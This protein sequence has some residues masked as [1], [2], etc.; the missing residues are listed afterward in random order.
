MLENTLMSLNHTISPPRK[1]KRSLEAD[2]LTDR[3]LSKRKTAETV[4]L[5]SSPIQLT[6]IRDLPASCNLDT[7]NLKDILGDPLI[8]ECWQF[9]FLFD[10]DFLMKHFDEDTRDLVQVRIV[11]GSWKR[12]DGNKI[13][14]DEA[15]TRYKNIQAI[16]AYMP[17]PFGTHHSKMM[18]LLRHDDCA[19]VVIHTANMISQD[20]TNMTQAV[21]RSP[22]LPLSSI[23][24]PEPSSLIGSGARFKRDLLAYLRV[25][26][27]KRTGPL[28]NQLRKFD[29]S[30]V[31]A[32]LV[33]STPSRQNLQSIDPT[34]ETLWGWPGLQ[35]ILKHVPAKGK[36]E[37]NPQIVA[38]ISSIA[39]LGQ[40]NKWLK[41]TFLSTLS[42]TEGITDGAKPEL[43]IIFPTA[44]EIRR[45]LD[46]YISGGSIH[47][48]IQSP[49]Q[50][51]Q[52]DYLRPMMCHWAGD[53]EGREVEKGTVRE[54]GRRRAAPHIKTYIRFTDHSMSEIDWAMVTSANLSTQAWGAAVN[55][56]RE[57]RICSWEIGV[58]VWPDLL[59]ESQSNA[60]EM[61]PVFKTDMP[62]VLMPNEP[63]RPTGEHAADLSRASKEVRQWDEKTPVSKII[64]LRMPYDLPL[65]PYKQHELPWC[66]TAVHAEP[67]WMGQTWGN[68]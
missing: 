38:Q 45:S 57:V 52:L 26:G 47:T 1:R 2:A 63:S 42:T 27:Q 19:Q 62:S 44:D 24:H 11:H 3:G 12:E 66:A 59:K 20:W 16:Q 53:K 50:K 49:P 41:D 25:Y 68:P 6:K 48:K 35:N 10:V 58:L 30:Q 39:T 14:I 9:N 67:D 4:Q 29:F 65:V 15:C 34:E 46:G 33:A 31:R 60:V 32:A 64:G 56:S 36:S 37:A 8:K 43:S 7:V 54:A 51:R 5:L 13:R 55:A 22:L 61:V 40:T 23:D 21:W 17:E 18:I 28:A